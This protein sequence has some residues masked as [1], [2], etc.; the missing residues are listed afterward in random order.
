MISGFFLTMLF[1]LV[2]LLTAFLPTGSLP[3]EFSTA[4]SSLFGVLNTFSYLIAVDTLILLVG[5][6]IAFDGIV[7]LWN[8][9]NWIIRKIPGMQ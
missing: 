7:L 2:S 8:F 1:G 4:I 3:T 5:L 9:V 6:V